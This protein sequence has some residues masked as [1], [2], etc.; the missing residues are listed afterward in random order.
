MK[1]ILVVDDHRLMLHFMTK[2]LAEQ[3]HQVLTAQDGLSALDVLKTDTPDVMFVD[4]IMP[5]IGGEKLCQII[6]MI[7]R[8]KDV[9]LVVL[10]SVAAEQGERLAELGVNTYIPKGSFETMAQQVLAALD[11]LGLGCSRG[12]NRATAGLEGLHPGQPI[13][14]LLSVKRHFEV[15]LGSMGDGLLEI[16]PGARIVYANPSAISLIGIG[17]EEL[18]G[19][20]FIELF[21]EPDRQKIHHLLDAAIHST[22]RTT[23]GDAPVTLND[24]YVVLSI[25]PVKDEEQESVMIVLN[26]VTERERYEAQLQ[27]VNEELEQRVEERTAELSKTTEQLK[28]ELAERKRAEEGLR[29]AHEDLAKKAGDLQAANEK[30]FQYDHIVAHVLKAPLRAVHNYS[31]FLREELEATL[32]GDQKVYLDSLNRAVRQGEELVDD[33]LEFSMVDKRSIRK[34]TIDIGVFL[35]ELITSLDLPQDVEVVTANGWPTIDTDPTFLM[36]IFQNLI[37]NAIKFNRSPRRRVELG[38][39]PAGEKCYELFV[40][41]NGIGIEPHHHEQIFGVFHRLHARKEYEGSGMGLAICKRIIEHHGGKIW[42]ES[43]PGKGSTF[44]FTIPAAG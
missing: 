23:A 6:R 17:E 14:E 44:H 4:L 1:K 30:L 18:L 33:L 34:R 27:K 12:L 29:L 24:K 22:P 19:S 9:Y 13:R 38:W 2:L 42:I 39:V 15:I 20:N 43:E 16:T 25:L 35:Q 21:G 26:D 32:N 8:L 3:G 36:L 5:N 28:L 40:R 37:E 41:D 7:P 10:S 31:D 11:Q